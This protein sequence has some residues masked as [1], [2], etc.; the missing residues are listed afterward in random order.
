M[1]CVESIA[2][3]RAKAERVVLGMEGFRTTIRSFVRVEIPPVCT[4][5]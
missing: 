4:K 5:I 1:T 3:Q 2:E